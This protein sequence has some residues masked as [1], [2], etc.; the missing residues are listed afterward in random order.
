MSFKEWTAVGQL[1]G[2]VLVVGW[3]VWDGMS[4]G[5]TGLDFAGVAVR[6]CWAIVA[7][8]VLNIALTILSVIVGSILAGEELK[9]EKADE[10]DH[11]IDARSGRNSGYV[12]SSAAGLSLL[13]LALGVDP[14]FAVYALFAAP[15]LGGTT[16]ALSRLV[17][18]RLG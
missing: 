13:A 18:Y 1:I 4:G 15:M 14:V 5:G 12:T 7:M 3:L 8:I 17:Y 16:D 2:Q 11:S 9:D 6:L 10:R